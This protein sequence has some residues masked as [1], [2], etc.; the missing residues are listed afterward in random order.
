MMVSSEIG[1]IQTGIHPFPTSSGD[2]LGDKVLYRFCTADVA[3]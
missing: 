2:D 3:K 1:V